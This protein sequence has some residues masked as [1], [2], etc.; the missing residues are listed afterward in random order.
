LTMIVPGEGLVKPSPGTIIVKPS[1]GTI[2]TNLHQV[3]S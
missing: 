3:R 1:S 2:M